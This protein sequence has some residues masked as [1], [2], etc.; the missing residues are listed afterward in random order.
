MWVKVRKTEN[1]AAAVIHTE[2]ELSD[3]IGD[4]PP[5]ETSQNNAGGSNLF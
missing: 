4:M 3:I 2:Q 5:M 1:S